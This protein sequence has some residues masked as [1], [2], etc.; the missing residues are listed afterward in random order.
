MDKKTAIEE[1]IFTK[2]GRKWEVKFKSDSPI[3][4]CPLFGNYGSCEECGYWRNGKCV[5]KPEEITFEEMIYRVMVKAKKRNCI[6]VTIRYEN[7][8]IKEEKP[9]WNWI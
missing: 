5:I 7:K 6:S 8:D 4:F 2:R 1:I 3:P 9:H